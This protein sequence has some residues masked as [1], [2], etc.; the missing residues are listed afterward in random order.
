[1]GTS[2]EHA[3]ET[4]FGEMGLRQVFRHISQPE[5]RERGIEGLK[6]AVEDELAI[7]AHLQL[8]AIPLEFQ[9]VQSP[10]VGKRR[11]MQLWSIRSC[12]VSGG[13]RFAK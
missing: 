12:G 8:A 9:G 7:D 6:D 1:M 11:L 4:P 10:W 3:L 13:D 2:F 5:T